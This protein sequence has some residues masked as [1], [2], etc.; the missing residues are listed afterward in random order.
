[1]NTV[2]ALRARTV[3]VLALYIAA[4]LPLVIA[5]EWLMQGSPGWLSGV[6]AVIA[7]STSFMAVRSSGVAQRLFLAVAMMLTVSCVLAT[8]QGKPWQIDVHMYF[9]ASLA[10]LVAFCDWRPILAATVTVALH[11]LILNFALPALVFPGGGA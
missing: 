5:L 4:H 3:R 2:E 7:T 10:M 11:H 8:M 9:F 1:M 6:M